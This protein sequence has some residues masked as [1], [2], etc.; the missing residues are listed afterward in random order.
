MHG[1]TRKW[2]STSLRHSSL[3][4]LLLASFVT[5][6]QDARPAF[7]KTRYSE[8]WSFLRDPAQRADALDGLKYIALNTDGS[9]WLSLGGEVRWH[10]D[11]TGNPA[12]GGD[13]QDPR[14]VLLQRYLLHGD[15]SLGKRL[16]LFG[17][18][19]SA[20]ESGR[21]GATTPIDENRLDLQQA[22][23]DITLNDGCDCAPVLR[24]GRQEMAYGSSRLIDVREGPNVR[25][26]FEGARLL[27]QAGA[28][29]ADVIATRPVRAQIGNFDDR[30]DR[31]QALWGLY[32]SHPAST[33]LPLGSALDI[34][35]LGYRRQSARFDQ[36]I[37]DE[38]RHTL[39]ARLWG[40]S[41]GWD[42]NWE[43]IAQGGRFGKGRIAAWSLSAD[44]GYTW[45]TARGQP[46]FGLSVNAASGDKDPDDNDLQSFNALF[47][48]GNYFSELALLGPRNFVNLH[49]SL[50]FQPTGSVTM[51]ADV[52]F[53]WRLQTQDGVYTP[54][55]GLLRSAQ[56][57]DARF[58]GTE[59]SFNTRWDINRRL[60]LTAIYSRFFP[61]RFI[62]ETG[63]ASDI[64]YVEFTLQAKF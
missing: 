17:Q 5:Q 20:L 18:L 27:I 13:P 10:Y 61:G 38:Q 12:W 39:G 62:R 6:A 44:T 59:L 41:L 31:D 4:S 19:Y 50:S 8:D 25:R 3:I 29:R 15:L 63:P 54:G 2:H 45:S 14:G 64:D 36:G 53:F 33:Q 26:T 32:A 46:R 37:A 22:F 11:Y 48:R 23:A 56:G 57:S 28:W 55:S 60:S 43:L 34:Y 9:H 24:V 16:R 58:V 52:D 30:I 51:T 21:A 7:A 49:P 47:P 1:Q 42:W 40:A 35:Y